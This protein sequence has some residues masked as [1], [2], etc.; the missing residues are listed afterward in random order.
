MSIL[1]FD[2]SALAKRYMPE[3]GTNWVRKQTARSAGNDVVIAQITPIELYSAIAR[4]YHDSQIDLIRLQEFRS[5]FM[6][7]VQNQYLVLSLSSAMITRALSLHETYRLRAY[8]SIQLASALELNRRLAATS[9]TLTLV[10]ADVRL[11][12][13]AA[14]AGLPTD[15]PDNYA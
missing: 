4:Q 9:Q 10:A 5:L 11:L 3:T 15:N 7:H 6:R 2:S 12:Q 13:S 8:D 1:Y 14:S